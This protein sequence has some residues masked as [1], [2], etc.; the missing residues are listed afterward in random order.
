M[1]IG[2]DVSIFRFPKAGI[3]RYLKNILI[4][5]ISLAE[6]DTFF[7]YS[8]KEIDSVFNKKNLI[9]RFGKNLTRNFGSFWFQLEGEKYLFQDKIDIFWGQNHILPFRLAKK[10]PTLLTVHDLSFYYIYQTLPFRSFLIIRTLFFKAIRLATHILTPSNFV[11]Q[12]LITLGISPQK[13]SVVYEGAEEIFRPLDKDFAKKKIKEKYGIEKDFILSVGAIEP[14]KNYSLLIKAFKGIKEDFLLIIIGQKGWKNKEI[15]QLV[16][17][18]NLE[19]RVIFFFSVSDED[20][21]YF[22]NAATLF[23]Y[24]SLY[25]GFG[26][27]VLEAMSCGV[28]VITSNA[29]SLPEVGGDAVL[30]FSPYDEEGLVSQIKNIISSPSLQRELSEKSKERAK[31]FSF[32]KSAEKILNIMHQLGRR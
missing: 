20:L 7:L 28:P 32:K 26:L 24:P 6:N 5:L 31:I 8:P 3:A 15:F 2:V 30:Y 27:P 21:C 25:E 4:N 13:I 10:I 18:L 23:V 11:R 17:K 12:S 29:S 22:Y 16:K 19:R 9:L 14:R 1:K